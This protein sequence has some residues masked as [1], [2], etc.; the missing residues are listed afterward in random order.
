MKSF[1]EWHQERLDEM[2]RKHKKSKPVVMPKSDDGPMV[3]KPG[4]G[5]AG[6]QELAFRTGTHAQGERRQRT[7][8]ERNRKSIQEFE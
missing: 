6:H 8:R 7:R 4:L 1:A 2:A 5:R 3:I